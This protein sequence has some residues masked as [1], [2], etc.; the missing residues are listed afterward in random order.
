MVEPKTAKL[1]L[2][3]LV[4]VV[5]A[6]ASTVVRRPGAAWHYDGQTFGSV[7]VT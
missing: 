1:V 7:R 4:L 5:A 3:L 6:C 2:V